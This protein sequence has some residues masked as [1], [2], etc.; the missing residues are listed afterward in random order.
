M[1]WAA[2]SLVVACSLAASAAWAQPVTEPALT[3]IM[4]QRG[5]AFS[6]TLDELQALSGQ[7]SAGATAILAGYRALQAND[8]PTACR[9]WESAAD[10]SAEAAHLT[11]ECYEHGHG[12]ATDVAHAIALYTQAADAG[13]GKSSC[14]L[15]NLYMAGTGV[16]R[17]PERGVELCRQGAE[18]GD[19]DAQTDLGN[20]Y[21]RG[22][23]VGQDYA[24][25]RRWYQLAVTGY[26][27]PNAAFSL[28][29]LYWNGDG[30]ERDHAQ[31][32]I[33]LRMAY[34]GGRED[35]AFLLALEALE[36][37]RVE[38]GFEVGPLRE[39]ESWLGR[40]ELDDA[41]AA[42]AA[43]LLEAVRALLSRAGS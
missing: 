13:F 27:H 23:G 36:R 19:P 24:E 16:E 17:D 6:Q 4:R 41:N 38:G 37:A 15:G 12:G 31:A 43:E 32:A 25:A 29:Y 22:Q 35:A 11:A 30:G 3:E 9:A 33:Y 14:A 21:L 10:V 40:V 42:E 2:A 34:E 1:R 39:A 7:G 26:R 20:F 18:R 8:F 5:R 28:G